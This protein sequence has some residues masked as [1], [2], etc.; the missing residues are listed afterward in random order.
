MGLGPVAQNILITGGTGL[1][2]SHLSG[3]LAEQGHNIKV[4]SRNSRFSVPEVIK[5]A[6]SSRI[7]VIAGELD[8]RPLLEEL[9]N[10]SDIIFYKAASVGAAGAV[11]N[12]KDFVENNLGA[13]ANLVDV[14][15]ASKHRIKHIILGSS[16]SVYG[17][18]VYS[19]AKCHLVRPPLRYKL[20]TTTAPI[21]WDPVCPTCGSALTP[22]DTREDSEKLGESTYAVTKKAQE[23]LLIGACKLLGIDLS[24][25]RYGTIIGAG[26]SWHNPFTRFLELALSGE[27]PVLHEDGKQSRDFMFVE[28]VVKANLAIMDRQFSGINIYNVTS[29][30]ATALIDFATIIATDMATALNRKPALPTIDGKFI[31][32]DVR[33][34]HTECGKLAS[35]TGIKPQRNLKKGIGQL[36]EWFVRK[37][38]HP[39]GN[40]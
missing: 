18:G 39:V 24:I 2:G 8:N 15:R 6:H 35:A 9:V 29:G 25:F 14:L 13:T 22:A 33:H 32:G 26:Q 23:E 16:I 11:E 10:Q 17:E 27:A 20:D 34:C 5:D 1:I 12:A 40:A 38:H 19:C 31:P 36:V 28:D 37:K 7:E 3:A 21:H 30:E 4:L